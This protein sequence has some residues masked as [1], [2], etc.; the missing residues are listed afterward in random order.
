MIRE[1]I[2][3]QVQS[4][5]EIIEKSLASLQIKFEASYIFK[6]L[7]APN[8]KGLWSGL[9]YQKSTFSTELANPADKFAPKSRSCDG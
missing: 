8:S 2:E 3:I 4:H 5:V 1:F 9:P 7:L 6:P